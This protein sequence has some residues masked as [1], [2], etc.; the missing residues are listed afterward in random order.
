MA[1][2]ISLRSWHTNDTD[3]LARHANNIKIFANLRDGF[4]HPYNE[5]DAQKF[6]TMATETPPE[7]AKIWAIDI[8]G[9]AAG[10]IGIHMKEDVYRK[11]A[12][13]GYWLAEKYWGQG[14][15]TYCVKQVMTYA[16]ENYDI[17]RIYAE[18]YASNTAS[19][20]VLHHAGFRHEATL[21]K[22]VYKLD[23]YLDTSLYAILREEFENKIKKINLQ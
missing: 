2:I 18:I 20:K 5:S 7:K 1:A 14:I 12:E 16:F 21:N 8:N 23:E 3:A 13:L 10:S 4:P 22:N 19:R 11:N 17:R 9:E 15:M 6:I